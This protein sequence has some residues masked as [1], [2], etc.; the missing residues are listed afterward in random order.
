MR[1]VWQSASFLMDNENLSFQ[2][3]FI[4]KDFQLNGLCMNCHFLHICFYFDSWILNKSQE[5]V[6]D[7][8]QPMNTS[9]NCWLIFKLKKNCLAK[10]MRGWTIS[11]YWYEE[12]LWWSAS[13]FDYYNIRQRKLKNICVLLRKALSNFHFAL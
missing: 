3:L 8:F 12:V 4:Q 1:D 10:D 6:P 7:C 13:W 2:Y 5:Q 9:Q 11:T